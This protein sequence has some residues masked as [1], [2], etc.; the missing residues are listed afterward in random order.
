[1]FQVQKPELLRNII[2]ITTDRKTLI[3]QSLICHLKY[4]FFLSKFL[5]YLDF[6]PTKLASCLRA[7]LACLGTLSFPAL[8]TA[9]SYK[10]AHT[11]KSRAWL[12]CLECDSRF[13]ELFCFEVPPNAVFV[14]KRWN[15]Q[16]LVFGK[17][18]VVWICH[19]WDC[20]YLSP[21]RL[22]LFVTC[23]IV[24]IYN[25]WDCLY[26]SPVRLFVFVT[27]EILCVGLYTIFVLHFCWWK[28]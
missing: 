12:I 10:R 26:M 17:K 13:C 1:M 21:V 7:M 22:F 2:C 15:W 28:E 14:T 18:R 5:R 23:E 11:R 6:V 25:L 4:Y 9:H 3:S 16:N 20:L 8:H 19:L 27:C 24:C